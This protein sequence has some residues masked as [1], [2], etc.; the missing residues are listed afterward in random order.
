MTTRIAVDDFLRQK[1]LALVGAS[2]SG[3]KFGSAIYRE[4]RTKGYHV[5]AVHPG[6]DRIEGDACWPTMA[7]LPEPVGGVVVVVPPAK[8]LKVVQEAAAA[9]IP[10]IW[11]QPGTESPAA[12][13]AARA[14][15]IEVVAGHCLLMF[16]EPVGWFHGFHRTLWRW[17]GKL[18]E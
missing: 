3:H 13:E 16:V 10:R 9:Q 15:G 18:P 11:L 4:L 6:A 14:A 2:R 17:L 12:I 7:A 5:L 1:T 8:A